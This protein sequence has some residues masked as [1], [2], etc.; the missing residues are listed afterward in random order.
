MSNEPKL[1][2]WQDCADMDIKEVRDLY[3]DYVSKGQV[4]LIGSFG[5]GRV[6]AQK[7][8]GMYIHT[9]DGRKI[10]DM[11]GG[12]GVLNHGH[13]HPRILEARRKFQE[14]KRMEVHKNFLS[15]Y[16]AGLSHNIAQLLPEGLDISYFCNSGAEAVEGAVKL[17]YKY[18]NGERHYI[19]NADIA[20]HG[21]LL[22][23]AGLTSSPELHFHFPTIPGIES[24]EYDNI[25]SVKRLV[26]QLRKAD[27][28]SD[29]YAIIL[30]PLNGSSLRACSTEFL[31]E[32]RKI[33]T[34]EGILLIFDE[35]YT[36][37]G[38]TGALFNF[39]N[40]EV[41]PDIIT[42]AKSFGGGK[43]SISGYTSRTPFFRK[44]Y[45]NPSDATLHSTTYFGFGEE[46]ITAMEAIN[47]IQEEGLVQRSREI[48]NKLNPGLKQLQEKYPDLIHDVRGSGALNGL[49]LDQEVN[50]YI[51]KS[52]DFIPG[53]MFRDERFMAKL[54]TGAVISELF[55]E[56]DILTFFGSNREI[57][58]IISPSL[59]ATDEEV[60][61]VLNALDQTLAKGKYTLIFNFARFKFLNK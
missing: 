25:A 29:V 3:R 28:S 5:F 22:G 61:R 55:N 48:F 39:M 27:G 53:E 45:D 8:E 7:A 11:T 58:L 14:Q 56:H 38:K 13:N 2:S 26:D 32:V 37:W 23:A 31:Q 59:I 10:L 50:K 19:L 6:T 42:Y 9:T 1:Y 54:F 21:K 47:V 16:I 44:A 33:C 12:I 15:Q 41:D 17:A 57:P 20:F 52:L 40:H 34:Q 4:D 46:C 49:V 30:E 35:V 18:H 51:K 43:S 24:F 60:E 36:G